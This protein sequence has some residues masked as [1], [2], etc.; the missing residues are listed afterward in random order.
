M[1]K[2][3]EMRTYKETIS[4]LMDQILGEEEAVSRAARLIGD[5]VMRGQVIH[6]IGPGGHSN[7][8]VEELFS[9]AGGLACVNAILDPGTN[10]SHGGFRS[11]KVERTPG[12]AIPVLESYGVGQ[13]PGEVL[14]IINAY[15]IN[16]MTIDCALEA[17][18]PSPSPPPPSPGSCRRTIPHAIPQGRTFLS[19][20]M[21][22]LT[23]ICPMATPLWSWRAASRRW[24]PRPRFATASR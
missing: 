11:M 9:R 16:C 12:Y 13:T 4:S 19:P 1:E 2:N 24:G 20:W 21:C 8:A 5:S 6:A 7:M 22:S 23:T 17:K 15:G 10:L 3:S 18:P 14:L